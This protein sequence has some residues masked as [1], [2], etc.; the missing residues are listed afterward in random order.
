MRRVRRD[1]EAPCV[2]RLDDG[3][4]IRGRYFCKTPRGLRNVLTGLRTCGYVV[5]NARHTERR[6][7]MP[8]VEFEAG[9]RTMWR[10]ELPGVNVLQCR[11]CSGIIGYPWAYNA[12]HSTD[13]DDS[14]R[15]CEFCGV[16]TMVPPD[17]HYSDPDKSVPNCTE[18]LFWRGQVY[19]KPPPDGG[20]PYPVNLDVY[21]AWRWAP[22]ATGEELVSVVLGIGAINSRRDWFREGE[23]MDDAAR[24]IA[25]MTSFV[26][27]FT[28]VNL[29]TWDLTL[30]PLTQAHRIGIVAV[31]D[32]VTKLCT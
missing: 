20:I 23:V 17:D 30:R 18:V 25:D 15:P 9:C 27:N 21:E 3:V 8:V 22:L 10:C 5:Q 28:T 13:D 26:G 29:S 1:M 16:P 4:W 6:K 24:R 14:G 31:Y 7:D 19:P 12:E 32:A 2:I 11:S